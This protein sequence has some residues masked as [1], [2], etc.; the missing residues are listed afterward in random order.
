M[1]GTAA[2]GDLRGRLEALRDVVFVFRAWPAL[3]GGGR[4]YER[5][6]QDVPDAVG[7]IGTQAVHLVVVIDV[8][9]EYA[10]FEP[11]GVLPRWIDDGALDDGIAVLEMELDACSDLGLAQVGEEFFHLLGSHSRVL[12]SG[13]LPTA[14]HGERRPRVRKCY[15]GFSRTVNIT[16]ALTACPSSN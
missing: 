5:M 1:D 14:C 3:L 2:D 15:H 8:L 11:A 12:S 9:E 4:L 10:V 6:H 16:Y 7:F 13:W